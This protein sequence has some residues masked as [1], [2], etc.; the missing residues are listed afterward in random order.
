MELAHF[1]KNET[2]KPH[3]CKYVT[4]RGERFGRKNA[5]LLAYPGAPR[6]C[7]GG[8]EVGVKGKK[9][10]WPFPLLAAA[11]W[12]VSRS[13]YCFCSSDRKSNKTYF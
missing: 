13:I 9:E 10:I 3:V 5:H 6:G 11:L 8:S 1:C 4:V 7:D 12:L 2:N